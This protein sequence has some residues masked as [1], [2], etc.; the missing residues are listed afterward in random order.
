MPN[1]PKW[2]TIARA[3]KQPITAVLSVYIHLMVIAS[4]ATERGRT[5]SVCNEDIASALD[6]ECEQVDAILLAMQGRV[7]EGDKLSGWEKRQVER[8]DGGAE[9]AKAWREAKKAE[10]AAK[11]NEIERNQDDANATERNRTQSERERTPDKDTDKEYINP[12]SINA[13]ERVLES[14]AKPQG[15]AH[16]EKFAM[17]PA[18]Q[19]SP[20]VADLARQSGTVLLPADLPDLVAH[21]LTEP[22][23]VRTQ[24]EWDKALLQT[25]KHRA[26]RA[27]SP[28][29]S[30][31]GRMPPAD[32]FAGK[33]YGVGV[34]D[35]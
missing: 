6:L 33:N 17:H 35:L 12:Q 3:S 10:K 18:W 5:Q 26:L 20:H 28:Q 15:A 31:A 8:E 22:Q 14:S 4:N 29:P 2:R 34:Q 21:W 32:N 16:P 27:A 30:R 7:L 9:R 11:P 19:P 24:S 1:D 23:T 25:A 13:G